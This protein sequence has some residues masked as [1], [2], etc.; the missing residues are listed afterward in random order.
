MVVLGAEDDLIEDLCIGA[1]DFLF[2]PF[3]VSAGPMMAYSALCAEL[4]PFNPFGVSDI[5][6][7][8]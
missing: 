8:N 6:N 3:R 1:H 4:L 2:N 7:K 5:T